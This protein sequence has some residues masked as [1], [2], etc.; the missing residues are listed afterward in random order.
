MLVF[1]APGRADAVVTQFCWFIGRVPAL[2]DHLKFG[3]QLIRG[4]GLK[5]AGFYHAAAKRGG[6]LLVLA[7]EIVFALG[8]ADILQNFQ[9]LAIRV[10]RFACPPPKPRETESRLNGISLVFFSDGGKPKYFPITLAR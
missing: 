6:R 9:G 8:F 7:G 3:R 10:Q 1:D 2:E 5:P 4:V